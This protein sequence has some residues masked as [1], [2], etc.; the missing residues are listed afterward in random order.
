MKT[1]TTISALLFA[2]LFV[3]CDDDPEVVPEGTVRLF[4]NVNHH[5][6]PIPNATVFRMNGTIIFPGFD[7]SLYETR[8]VTDANGN[9]AITDVGNGDKQMV[10]YAKGID[11]SWDTTQTTPVRGYYLGSFSTGI[12]ESKDYVVQIP[13]SE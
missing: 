13:V 11:P 10:L 6:I 12:G 5:G 7:T 2:M 8:Y 3:S 1:I 9:L 4:I